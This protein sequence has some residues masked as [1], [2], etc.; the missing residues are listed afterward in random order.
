[1]SLLEDYWA[2]LGIP[3]PFGPGV[4]ADGL[5]KQT[6]W[7]GSGIGGGESSQGQPIYS[8]GF[9]KYDPAKTQYGQDT[10]DRF[11]T[12]GRYVGTFQFSDPADINDMADSLAPVAAMVAMAY[13]GGLLAD[14]FGAGAGAGAGAGGFMGDATAA[15]YGGLDAASAAY[16]GG[17]ATL[18]SALVADSVLPA[19]GAG[20]GGFMGDATAA[21]YGGLDA[22]SASTL[23]GGYSLEPGVLSTAASGLGSSGAKAV[24]DGATS[25]GSMA[26]GAGKLGGLLAGVSQLLDQGAAAAMPQTGVAAAAGRAGVGG[27]ALPILAAVA[28]V[29]LLAFLAVNNKKG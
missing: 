13:G 2:A 15:G 7:A 27:N 4:G 11:D 24:L 17:G 25:L 16:M 19:A 21:G 23:G 5:T 6:M 9:I 22:A 12:S 3:S 20:A 18:N 29:L 8:D 28:G 10:F 14:T 26:S 1:M